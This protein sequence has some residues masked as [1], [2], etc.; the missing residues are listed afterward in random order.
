[1][2]QIDIKAKAAPDS[3][4]NLVEGVDGYGDRLLEITYVHL[5]SAA[6]ADSSVFHSGEEMQLVIAAHANAEIARPNVGYAIYGDGGLLFST[7][8]L[9]SDVPIP[10]MSPGET[11]EI[12]F[13]VVLDIAPGTYSL[14]VLAADNEGMSSPD[15]GRHHDTRERLG[16]IDVAKPASQIF[17]YLG[18]ARLPA[19]MLA[20]AVLE[21]HAKTEKVPNV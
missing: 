1:L 15:A 13:R 10:R 21:G 16:P 7:S 19:R 8:A 20:F 14:T 11:V 18:L 6:G 9:N 12:E 4:R 2:K 5:A 17:F 3:R